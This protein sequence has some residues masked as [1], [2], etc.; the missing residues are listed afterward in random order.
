MVCVWHHPALIM[1]DIT[2]LSRDIA[3]I[4]SSQIVVVMRV[5]NAASL[6]L[7]GTPT[8]CCV[9]GCAVHLI[10]AVNLENHRGTL[11]TRSSVLGEQ[12]SRLDILRL[13]L[14]LVRSLDLVTGW[15]NLGIAHATLPAGRQEPATVVRRTGSNKLAPRT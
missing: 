2:R 13:A 9:A 10:A 6:N 4:D 8:E 14:V 5:V 11:G 15:T 3:I 1:D 12:T 7:T